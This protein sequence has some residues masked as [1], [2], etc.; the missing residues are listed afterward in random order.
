MDRAVIGCFNIPIWKGALRHVL[1]IVVL[2]RRSGASWAFEKE[3]KGQLKGTLEPGVQC[4]TT[5]QEAMPVDTDV[6]EEARVLSEAVEVELARG[7]AL[8]KQGEDDGWETDDGEDE[9]EDFEVE[10]LA[11][12]METVILVAIDKDETEQ[13]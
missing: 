7:R 11:E 4:Q 1:L 6:S 10:Q 13:D 2:I 12:A 3:F 8:E 9:G 5:E